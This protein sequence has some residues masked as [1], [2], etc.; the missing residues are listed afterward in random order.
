M[1]Q[2]LSLIA[3]FLLVFVL[4]LFLPEKHRHL[5]RPM[6]CILLGIQLVTNLTP[7]EVVL[8]GGMYH[9]TIP[10]FALF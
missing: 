5:I 2:E 3:V 10:R 8:F 4:D 1:H 9:S 7:N 6:A